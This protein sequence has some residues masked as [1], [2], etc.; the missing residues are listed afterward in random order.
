MPQWFIIFDEKERAQWV[1][2]RVITGGT[3]RRMLSTR[4]SRRADT[5]I[6]DARTTM[7]SRTTMLI[8]SS[9]RKN[10]SPIDASRRTTD[11]KRSITTRYLPVL[12]FSKS[13]TLEFQHVSRI[14]TA[15][16]FLF[17]RCL[18]SKDEASSREIRFHARPLIL[19]WLIDRRWK[20]CHGSRT[21]P[22]RK[23]KTAQLL[24]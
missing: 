13:K 5:A 8:A 19:D 4:R 12:N 18:W 3:T 16:L 14:V 20:E 2:C 11:K 15:K 17:C 6:I 10:R 7:N 21:Y 9:N 22:H 1:T 24:F 23:I